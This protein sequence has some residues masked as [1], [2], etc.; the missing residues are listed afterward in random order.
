MEQ[1]DKHDKFFDTHPEVLD[2][3]LVIEV[4]MENEVEVVVVD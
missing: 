4:M 3:D 1:F 2:V